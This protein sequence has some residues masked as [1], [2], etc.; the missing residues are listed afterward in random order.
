LTMF[1]LCSH[2]RVSQIHARVAVNCEE[3]SVAEALIKRRED[4]DALWI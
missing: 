1:L 4:T 3:K 2:V